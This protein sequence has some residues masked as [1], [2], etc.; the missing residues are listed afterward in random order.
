MRLIR[1]I[2]SWLVAVLATLWRLFV[3]SA[4]GARPVH[5]SDNLWHLLAW[6]AVGLVCCVASFIAVW[7]RRLA[8]R[9]FLLTASLILS[10]S[11]N[12]SFRANVRWAD[13]WIFGPVLFC[14]L[15]WYLTGRAGWT[16][17]RAQPQFTRRK[18]EIP[19]LLVISLT[20]L[21]V[22][23]A[24]LIT[25]LPTNLLVDC[26]W[27]DSFTESHYNGSEVFV[28]TLRDP[29]VGIIGERFRGLSP[30]TR[31][32]LIANWGLGHNELNGRRFASR[33]LRSS[34]PRLR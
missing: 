10:F 12:R 1:T 8:A 20:C 27:P 28:A 13:A 31:Y 18:V 2:V 21:V 23:G 29:G 22:I 16:P 15:F 5:P 34:G 9:G 3:L 6:L 24:V 25:M 26:S 32:V 7:N 30:T 4:L 11:L 14:G 17:L 19:I 33:T